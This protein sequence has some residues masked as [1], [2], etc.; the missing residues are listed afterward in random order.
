[1]N[2]K[3]G[4]TCVLLRHTIFI[5]LSEKSNYMVSNLL[6]KYLWLANVIYQ[7]NGITF[8]QINDK[9]L[10]NDLSE[11]LE[12]PKRTFHKWRIAVEEL[13]GIIIDCDRK[14]GYRFFIHDKECLCGNSLTGWLFSTLSVGYKL[15]RYKSIKDRILL[16]DVFTD[17]DWLLTILEA[18][19]HNTRLSITY[20][21][22]NSDKET[23]FEVEPY[24][25]KMFLQRWYLIAKSVHFETPRIYALDRI[26]NLRQ[27]D[28]SFEYPE[29]FSPEQF[30]MSSYGIIVDDSMDVENVELK[31]DHSQ[32]EYMRSLPLHHSQQEIKQESEYS[33]F[34][35][36]LIPTFDFEQKILSMGEYVEVISPEWFRKRV[37][38]RINRMTTIYK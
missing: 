7:S 31:V 20:K 30:F 36:T 10:T 37:T 16:E 33:I 14:N 25:L 18:L 22:F 27:T 12:L 23:T 38:D 28:I 26:I 24:C 1:M 5:I 13:F 32:V 21:S 17:N 2:T 9:W 19:H 15:E 4:D 11:G 6:Q 8:E 3:L 34:R 29:N 35:L